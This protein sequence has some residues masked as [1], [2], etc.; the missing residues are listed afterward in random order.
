MKVLLSNQTTIRDVNQEFSKEFPFLKIAFYRDRQR[1]GEEKQLPEHTRLDEIA[2]QVRPTLIEIRGSDTVAAIEKRFLEMF[3]LP[4]QV[5][6]QAG[7]LWLETSRS[8][9]MSLAHQ[10]AMGAT[11][12]RPISFN[13]H[14]LFL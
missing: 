11:A 13:I 5:C 8:D 4:V 6:R 14:T 9:N 10:N 7:T 1:Q 12:S 3:N 2:G